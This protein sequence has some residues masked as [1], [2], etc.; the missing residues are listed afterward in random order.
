VLISSSSGEVIYYQHTIDETAKIEAIPKDEA[1]ELSRKFLNQRYGFNADDCTLV[2]DLSTIFDF[3]TDHTFA[4][5]NDDVAIPWNEKGGTGK[6]ISN[7]TTSGNQVLSYAYH[8]FRVPEDYKRDQVSQQTIS[9]NINTVVRIFHMIFFISAVYFIVA[10]RNHL[11]MHTTKR[12]YMI[13]ALVLFVLN[14]LG[15]ANNFESIL[16]QYPTTSSFNSYMIRFILNALLGTVMGAFY[17]LMPGLSG[18]LLHFEVARSRG[19]GSLLKYIHST[20]LS[21]E[22]AKSVFAGYLIFCIMLGLQGLLLKSGE[23][24]FDVW[25]EYS[26]MTSLSTS[27]FPFLAAITLGL[28][29]SVSEEVLYRLFGINVGK[30]LFRN[31]TIAVIISALLWGFAHTTYP[32]YPMWFRAVEVSILGFFMAFVY[33]RYGLICTMV[34]HYVFNVFW[35]FTAYLFGEAHIFYVVSSLIAL[36]LPLV[37]GLIAFSINKKVAERPL[38]WLLNA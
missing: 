30:K 7:I 13:I 17:F 16:S 8:H 24:F 29:A 9:E 28:Q 33:L 12:P 27:Y 23:Q 37:F 32:I 34:A 5:Q 20:F 11:A 19:E 3:R 18:E 1:R 26:W 38:R 4:W 21:R 36:S 22:V 6:L 15:F 10:K 14:L 31:T 2:G 25:V 35:H